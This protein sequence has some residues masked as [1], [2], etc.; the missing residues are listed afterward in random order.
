MN[1]LNSC[2]KNKL[3]IAD[4]QQFLYHP[5]GAKILHAY[6]EAFQ[7]PPTSFYYSHQVLTNYGNM[8]SAT[9][10]FVVEKFLRNKQQTDSGHV[11]ISALG[12]GFCSESMLLKY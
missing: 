9:V 5:G 4:I 7:V 6:I 11:V 12:P 2:Q 10:L 1:Y 8:S 3:T